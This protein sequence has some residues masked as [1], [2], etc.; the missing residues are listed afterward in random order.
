[1]CFYGLCSEVLVVA[2]L[3]ESVGIKR[4]NMKTFKNTGLTLTKINAL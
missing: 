3:G 1:M 4:Y 2:G